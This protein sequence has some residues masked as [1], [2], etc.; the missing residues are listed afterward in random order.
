[1]DQITIQ[2]IIEGGILITLIFL[3][4]RL[5]GV[6]KGSANSLDEIS[7]SLKSIDSKTSDGGND[8]KHHPPGS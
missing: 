8:P 1:M 5:I 7:D 4:G 2:T 6:L 3:G